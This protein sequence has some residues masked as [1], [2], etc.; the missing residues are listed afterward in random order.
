MAED[1]LTGSQLKQIMNQQIEDTRK[2]DTEA[3]RI[4]LRKFKEARARIANIISESQV[5]DLIYKYTKAQKQSLELTISDITK[6]PDPNTMYIREGMKI[7]LGM[8]Q[9]YIEGIVVKGTKDREDLNKETGDGGQETK[10]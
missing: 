4:E 2:R 8:V 7:G 6:V 10:E 5:I 1:T 3:E 9:Q